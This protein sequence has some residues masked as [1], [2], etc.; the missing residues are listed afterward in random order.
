MAAK[1][2]VLSLGSVLCHGNNM[3][4]HASDAT[5]IFTFDSQAHLIQVHKYCTKWETFDLPCRP[6]IYLPRN[7]KGEP[8]LSLM[9]HKFS[10][11]YEC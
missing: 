4:A 3:N 6:G 5:F 8:D 11:T 7:M 1:A 10:V 2:L 9:R